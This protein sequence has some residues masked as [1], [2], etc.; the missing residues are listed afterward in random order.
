M[1]YQT[2]YKQGSLAEPDCH[3]KVMALRNDKQG[4]DDVKV[5]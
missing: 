3:M 1:A 4:R 2:V 5:K